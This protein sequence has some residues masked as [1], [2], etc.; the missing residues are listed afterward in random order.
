MKNTFYTIVR[1]IQAILIFYQLKSLYNIVFCLICRLKIFILHLAFNPDFGHSDPSSGERRRETPRYRPPP[2]S[3]SEAEDRARESAHDMF[4][5]QFRANLQNMFA[6]MRRTDERKL[7]IKNRRTKHFKQFDNKVQEIENNENV[8]FAYSDIPWPSENDT[9]DD[10]SVLFD[11][12][13]LSTEEK[14]NY[15]RQQRIRWHPDKFS[16]TFGNHIRESDRELI[17]NRV[18]ILSQEIN[19]MV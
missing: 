11:N 6:E 16:Q 9:A 10:K 18:T 2:Q 1:T 14:K 19:K 5:E 15:V 17:I 7:Y 13:E 3:T 4:D 8:I 12:L